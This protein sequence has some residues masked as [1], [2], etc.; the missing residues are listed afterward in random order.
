MIRKLKDS[1]LSKGTRTAINT[2]IKEFGHMLKFDLDSNTKSISMEVMLKGEKEPLEIHIGCYELFE[3]SGEYQLRLFDIRSSRSWINTL[4]ASYLEGKAFK[5][6]EK[7]A[8]V[9]KIVI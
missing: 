8:R 2:Q 6:P 9:L 4:A 7:Y 5:I 3:K 1:A